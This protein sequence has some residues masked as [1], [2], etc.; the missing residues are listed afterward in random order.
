MRWTDLPPSSPVRTLDAWRESAFALER[1]AP[2]TVAAVAARALAG[3]RLP[4]VLVDA[5]A[6]GTVA[7][8]VR[9]GALERGG[10]L[11]GTPVYAGT[12]NGAIALVH[13]TRAIPGENDNATPLSLRLDAAVWSRANASLQPGEAVIGWFHS[14]PGIGAFFSD[15][16]RRTQAAF[17]PHAFSLGWVIDPVRDEHAW[18]V[19]ALSEPLPSASIVA[20]GREA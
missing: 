5:E 17:F 1:V 10:L 12:G 16:D 4:L 6:G 3:S 13:V 14:H 15:T 11:A 8:Y 9:A 18:F 2:A 19:G 20:I 7:R